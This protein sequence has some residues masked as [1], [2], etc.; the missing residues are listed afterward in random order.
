MAE[1]GSGLEA[2][3]SRIVSLAGFAEPIDGRIEATSQEREQ[4]A[5]LFGIESLASFTFDYQLQPVGNRPRA[6]F[7]RN[8]RGAD[9]ALQRHA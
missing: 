4:L 6:S 8:P 2:V 3:F 7:R 9:A 5:E 1:A